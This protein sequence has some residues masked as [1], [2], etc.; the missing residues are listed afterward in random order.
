MAASTGRA[1]SVKSDGKIQNFFPRLL[2][3]RRE[4]TGNSSLSLSLRQAPAPSP[5]CA[6][7]GMEEENDKEEEEDGC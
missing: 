7:L 3:W 5:L 4:Q 1:R 2:L 6:Q